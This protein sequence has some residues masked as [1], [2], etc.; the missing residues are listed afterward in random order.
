M[1]LLFCPSTYWL[2]V[3]QPRYLC[4]WVVFGCSFLLD[5]GSVMNSGQITSQDLGEREEMSF[6]HFLWCFLIDM[7]PVVLLCPTLHEGTGNKVVV[8]H[9]C[10]TQTVPKSK[11][12]IYMQ[13]GCCAYCPDSPQRSLVT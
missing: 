9:G 2:N 4:L 7:Q 8:S 11:G 10:L 5:T 13:C 12:C 6:C 1:L 3:L